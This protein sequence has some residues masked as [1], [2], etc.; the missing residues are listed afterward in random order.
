MLDAGLT[1]GL[2][3]NDEHVEKIQTLIKAFEDENKS[4]WDFAS[5]SVLNSLMIVVTAIV[6]I[7]IVYAML[8]YAILGII[9]SGLVYSYSTQMAYG[10]T[11]NARNDNWYQTFEYWSDEFVVQHGFGGYLASSLSK[12]NTLIQSIN[13]TTGNKYLRHSSVLPTCINM[14]AGLNSMLSS[15]L[16]VTLNEPHGHDSS[17]LEAVLKVMYNNLKDTALPDNQKREL[18]MQ[19]E[20]ARKALSDSKKGELFTK[21]FTKFVGTTDRIISILSGGSLLRTIFEG[22]KIND[23]LSEVVDSIEKITNNSLHFHAA[24]LESLK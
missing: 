21:I 3:E 24:K 17:R 4:L 6:I 9:V 10:K 23:E 7:F 20:L 22:R 1:S 13:N 8:I 2:I 15:I 11:D 14:L 18:V 16:V 5:T 19:T 12:I